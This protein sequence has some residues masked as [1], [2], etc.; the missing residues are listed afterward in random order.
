MFLMLL[1][2]LCCRRLVLLNH[3]LIILFLFKVV[4]ALYFV[5]TDPFLL[6]SILR[7][8]PVRVTICLQQFLIVFDLILRAL[9]GSLGGISPYL[10]SGLCG[11]PLA[12]R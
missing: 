11:L 6:L 5:L 2:I 9:P 12:W 3:L 1:S 10:S 7:G 4:L 8:E